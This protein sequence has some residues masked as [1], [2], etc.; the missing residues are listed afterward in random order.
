MPSKPPPGDSPRSPRARGTNAS[1]TCIRWPH[2]T[3][4]ETV[5]LGGGLVAGRAELNTNFCLPA[6]KILPLT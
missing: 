6:P 1:P 4:K 2:F 3:D 5:R